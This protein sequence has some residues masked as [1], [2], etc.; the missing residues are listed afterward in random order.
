MENCEI[1]VFLMKADRAYKTG[2]IFK[3]EN[4]INQ[5]FLFGT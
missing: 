3:V 5:L 1:F 2:L 4:S